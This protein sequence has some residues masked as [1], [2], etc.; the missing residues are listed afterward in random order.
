MSKINE[1]IVLQI[2]DKVD[3]CTAYLLDNGDG[4]HDRY[5]SDEDGNLSKQSSNNS[6]GIDQENIPKLISL[7]L[8]DL[9]MTFKNTEKEINQE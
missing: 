6:N 7:T 4:T 5:V 9:E 1:I 2:P 3:P 8:E